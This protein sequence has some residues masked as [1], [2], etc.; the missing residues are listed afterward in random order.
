MSALPLTGIAAWMVIGTSIA[1]KKSMTSRPRGKDR[2][3]NVTIQ[4]KERP[5]ARARP[6]PGFAFFHL[7]AQLDQ[8]LPLLDR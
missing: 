7:D 8:F 6:T 2:V 4:P 1:A 5:A 3:V